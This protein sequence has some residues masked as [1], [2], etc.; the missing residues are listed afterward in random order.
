MATNNQ[1]T[2][3]EDI[4]R[5]RLSQIIVNE[6]YKAGKFKIPIHL[7]LGHEA[8]VIGVCQIMENGDK[9]ILSHRNI[10]YNLARVGKLKPLLDEYFL[11]PTETSIHTGVSFSNE[12]FRNFFNSSMYL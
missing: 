12:K 4:L 10:A 2:I 5:L 9:L 8:I 6:H 1:K 11:K 3:A 7:A